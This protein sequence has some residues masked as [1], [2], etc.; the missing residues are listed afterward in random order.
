MYRSVTAPVYDG[1]VTG[2]KTLIRGGT[3]N[4]KGN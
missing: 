1:D 2:V 3:W 4:T